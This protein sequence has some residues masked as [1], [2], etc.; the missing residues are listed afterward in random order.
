MGKILVTGAGG[1]IG[2]ALCGVMRQNALDF[3]PVTRRANAILPE[4]RI[5]EDINPAT[6]WRGVLAD[7]GVVVHLAGRV[8]RMEDGASDRLVEY[9]IA[10][11][12]ATLNLARQ[13]ASAGVGRLIYL[14]SVKVH[15]ASTTG[16]PFSAADAPAPV[17]PYAISKWEAEQGLQ[18]LA[19]ETGL[20]VVVIRPPL[21]YGPKVKANFLA[22][23]R[24]VKRGI[25]L[26]L[27]RVE[28]HRSMIYVGN[29]ADLILRCAT[30]ERAAGQTFLAS[31]GH[32]VSSA[33]LVQALALAMGR[34]P[35]LFAVPQGILKTAARL[36]GQ[37]AL[38]ERIL[39]SLQVDIQATRS[40]LGWFPP[41]SFTVG[42]ERTVKDFLEADES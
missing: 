19:R 17:D 35:P 40:T 2:Q 34:R 4:A 37:R 38:A 39:G 6:D 22:L 7:A 27:A 24:L 25:P 8:H 12:E 26:P 33:E 5:V 15:G 18:Q 23:M 3:A 21:V 32:D 11:V 9:R 13:C 16:R 20:E 14:S 41:H 29:L 1:F 31:D 42:I 10:N 36:L 30:A 28:N